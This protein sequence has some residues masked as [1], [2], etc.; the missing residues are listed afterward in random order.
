M[1]IN[2]VDLAESQSDLEAVEDYVS[3]ALEQVNMPADIY[4]V[5]SR[6][7]LKKA[8]KALINLKKA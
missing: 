5:S 3:D 8:M 2:A 1:I 4:S 7:S 6:R